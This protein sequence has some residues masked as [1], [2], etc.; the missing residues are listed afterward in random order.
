MRALSIP[1]DLA[2]AV[3]QVYAWI[4]FSHEGKIFGCNRIFADLMG[5]TP[6]EVIGQH[7]RI[8]VRADEA[9]SQGYADFWRRL[10]AGET[11]TDQFKRYKKDGRPVWLQ[12]TYI[13]M[14]NGDGSVTTVM[15]IATDITS[16]KLAALEADAKLAAI[17]TTMAIIEFAPDGS[18]LE[19]NQVFLDTLGYSGEEIRGRHHRMFVSETEQQSDAYQ[20]FWSSLAK[21]QFYRGE[22]T[23]VGKAGN[24]IEL[25][26][27]H[28]PIWDENGVVVKVIKFAYDVTAQKNR[29]KAELQDRFDQLSQAQA[30]AKR[31]VE[32]RM[33]LDALLDE[34]STPVT[35]LWDQLLMLPLVGMIDRNRT[36]KI[37]DR[38]LTD[39]LDYRALELIIDISGVPVIDTD[40]AGRL[41][42][43]SKAATLMGCHSTIS[44]ISPEI[45]KTITLLGIE[46]DGVTTTGTLM[47]AI[48]GAYERLNYSLE[49]RS[50]AVS[51]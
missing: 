30:K 15:K 27:C 1:D 25:E 49:R 46:L 9:Q 7:H 24:P 5:Y 44:G 23:R 12:A 11:F 22:F 35:P 14:R 20:Q 13:P 31:E 39:I 17:G 37:M 33:K 29:V 10:K 26:A 48:S 43:I 19:A 21:G 50:T 28:Q 51:S 41:V 36:D 4:Q 6:D 40:T 8:F 34:V 18:I 47:D 32:Q 45:A 42:S 38:V 2:V 16:S 3:D